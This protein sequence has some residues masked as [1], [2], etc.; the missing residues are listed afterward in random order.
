MFLLSIIW[1]ALTYAYQGVIASGLAAL[2]AAT[3]DSSLLDQAEIT[4]DATI[5]LLTSDDILKESCD[6]AASG[7]SVC[8]ADQVSNT[9]DLCVKVPDYKHHRSKSSRVSGLSTCSIT[10]TTPMMPAGLLNTVLSWG[11]RS[12]LCSTMELTPLMTSEVFGMRRMR[13]VVFSLRRR[14]Q[15][16]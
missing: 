12:L 8:D 1:A 13:V 11:R 10:S 4:L 14:V 6:D 16:V 5:S 2:Y 9:V 3:G 15:A 7:G